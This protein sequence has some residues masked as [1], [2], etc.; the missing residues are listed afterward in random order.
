V[1]WKSKNKALYQKIG[2]INEQQE[3]RGW[4][5]VPELFQETQ[6]Y[7]NND[8]TAKRIVPV[9]QEAAKKYPDFDLPS[10]WVVTCLL[11]LDQ[12][13]RSDYGI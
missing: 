6:S 5:E 7:Y 4:D 10:L 3:V 1:F 8:I 9:A 11:K 13:N 2:D 12:K